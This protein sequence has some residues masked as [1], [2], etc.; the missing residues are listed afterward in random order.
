MNGIILLCGG[1]Q[2]RLTG[3]GYPK[4]MVAVNNEPILLRT[5][6][7]VRSLLDVPICV[8][9]QD[10]VFTSF[11]RDHALSECV[12]DDRPLVMNIERAM[13]QQEWTSAM[14]L[15]GDVCWSKRMLA[16]WIEEC[17]ADQS[18]LCMRPG[19]SLVTGKQYGEHF[20]VQCALRDLRA[21]NARRF[22]HL[23]DLAHTKPFQI[24]VYQ[25][26]DD[27]TEDIDTPQDI[28]RIVPLLTQFVRAEA[29]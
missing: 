4:Q 27:F 17:R 6:R 26:A 3:L 22:R 11:C 16:R 29:A 13:R 1:R 7:L 15:L 2:E 23:R 14:A 25:P 18:M 9:A 19:P 5:V 12:V 8:A 10:Q 20:A 24:S 28:R 21:V